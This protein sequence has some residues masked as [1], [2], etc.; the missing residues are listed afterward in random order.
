MTISGNV[1]ASPVSDRVAV[2]WLQPWATD[3]T[4]TTQHDNDIVVAI[5]SD[6]LSWDFTN[7]LNITEW[8][9]PD[10]ALL[11]DTINADKD[12]FRCYAEVDVFFDFQDNLH[13][14]FNVEKFNHFAGT[15]SKGNSFIYHWSEEYDSLS[16]VAN[17]WFDNGIYE[18]G[19]W[20]KY[21][22]RPSASVDPATGDIYCIYQRYFQPVGPSAVYPYPYLEGDTTDFSA[23]GFPNGDIWMTKST[24]GGYSWAEGINI[25]DTHTP[26]AAAGD[27]MSEIT[28]CMAPQ[29]TNGNCH[30]FY[31][32]DKDAGAVVQTEG[33]WTLN[34][35]IYHR[36]PCSSV[37]ESPRLW[38]VPMHVDGGGNTVVG[39]TSVA[40]ES[41]GKIVAKDFMLEQNYPNPFNPQT[42]IKYALKVDGFASLKVYNINGKEVATLLEGNAKA[43]SHEAIFD[44]SELSSGIYFY[45]LQTQ[46]Y[47][48]TKKM[49]LLK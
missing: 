25:T 12:T 8:I 19:A 44:G 33:D 7:P 37:P 48:Y 26:N 28:P 14:I 3:P 42:S 10:P 13:L 27:C 43:G 24:D 22:T 34:D 40:V 20:N 15:I 38:P 39:T 30:V 21:L 23:A 16:M 18:P 35:A 41:P 31:V 2:A 29:I 4:D 46:G 45:Q 17:G 1:A 47:T 49:A 11:P 5:S 32:L 6:G 36:V 9:E